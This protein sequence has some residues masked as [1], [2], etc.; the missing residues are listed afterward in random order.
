MFSQVNTVI[1]FGGRLSIITMET[2]VGVF[3]EWQSTWK[4]WLKALLTSG[5]FGFSKNSN[6]IV[7]QRVIL[8]R[9]KI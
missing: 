1:N 3:K 4:R 2:Q 5:D 8:E 6:H 7:T 9:K